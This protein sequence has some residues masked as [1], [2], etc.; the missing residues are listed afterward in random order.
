MAMS[1]VLHAKSSQYVKREFHIK[2]SLEGDNAV[3]NLDVSE[4][5][6][7]KVSGVALFLE[8][9]QVKELHEKLGELL[10]QHK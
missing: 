8:I 7:Y 10:K 1:A 6:A 4:N 2:C 9:N 3:V 5:E